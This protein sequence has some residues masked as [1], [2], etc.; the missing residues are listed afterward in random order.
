MPE[1]R[2]RPRRAALPAARIEDGV[3]LVSGLDP[4]RPAGVLI[5]GRLVATLTGPRATLRLDPAEGAAG[6]LLGSVLDLIDAAGT[7]LLEAPLDLTAARPVEWLG[8]ALEGTSLRGGFRLG[9]AGPVGPLLVEVTDGTNAVARGLALPDAQ[10]GHRFLLP[11]RRLVRIGLQIDLVLHIAGR[12]AG[13][14]LALDVNALDL[15]GY[16]DMVESGAVSGW[17]ARPSGGPAPGIELR[18]GGRMLARAQADR[19][20]PDLV[21]LGY[22]AAQAGF[23][24]PVPTDL[25]RSRPQLLEVV[26]EGGGPAL[27]DSPVLLPAL[28][29]YVGFFDGLDGPAINGWAM[30]LHDPSRHP[31]VE[32]VCDGE[33]IGAAIAEIHRGDVAEAGLPT[34]LCGVRITINRPLP[35]LFGRDVSLRVRGSDYVLPGSPQQIRPHPNVARF[36]GRAAAIPGPQLQRLSARLSREV[37]DTLITIVMPTYNTR[38]EW[39]YEALN[40][41]LGQWSANWELILVDDAS[42]SIHVAELLEA[43]RRHDRRIRVMRSRA[44]QGIAKTVNLGLRAARG[45]YVLVMDH[46]DVLEPDAVHKLALAARQTGAD[47]VYADEAITTEDINSIWR[48]AARPA[49]SYDY[50]LSHPYFVHPVAVRTEIVRRIGGWDESL[51]ISADVDYVLRVL[52]VAA[53]VAHVPAVLYRWRTH[54][55]SSGHRSMAQVTEATLACLQRHLDRTHPGAVAAPGLHFNNYRIDWPDDGGEVLIVIPTKNRVDLLRPCI[56]SIERTCAGE[57]Y[58]IV[59]I[60]HESTDRAT[61]AYL[62]RLA[63]RHTVMPYRGPFNYAAMNNLAVAEHGGGADYVLFLNNDVEARAPGWLPRL[64]SLA[65]REEVGAVCPLLLYGNGRVQHAGVILGFNDYADHA[66]K[67]VPAFDEQGERTH[68]PDCTLT[69]VRD[70]SAVTAACLMTRRSAFER[71]GGFDP[72][73]AVAFNDTDLCLRLRHAGYKVLYDG[74]TVL[75][76]YESATRSR[77]DGLKHPRDNARLRRLWATLIDGGDPYYSPLLTTEGVDHALRADPGCKGRPAARRIDLRIT[78]GLIAALPAPP[79]EHTEDVDGEAAAAPDP[80]PSTMRAPRRNRRAPTA[81]AAPANAAEEGTVRA[82]SRSG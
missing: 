6:T 16:V 39:L 22:P 53:S 81:G 49:F 31:V 52:E 13:T 63:A 78:P 26:V 66:M 3:L 41:V 47:L 32:A 68:G 76:H 33:V 23:S 72:A 38:R 21:A 75:N 73:F 20:R 14:P 55:G 7:P 28:P 35:P 67:F 65:G 18:Q 54:P 70:F 59:V 37:A 15:A 45:E 74:F 79:D 43:A 4:D 57:R 17:I 80:L 40:S 44:N 77:L 48:V 60:D 56:E 62:A 8:W 1:S 12:P 61:R 42:P 24:L 69:S 25:D 27:I 58:R 29:R 10:G 11:L 64:R 51:R 9:G 50:Y 34:G 36:L 71:I 2:S 46:D 19:P 82:R 30:D 5:D